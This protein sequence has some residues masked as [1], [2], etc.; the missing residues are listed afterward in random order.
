MHWEDTWPNYPDFQ[1]AVTGLF[2][3]MGLNGVGNRIQSFSSLVLASAVPDNWC[4]KWDLQRREDESKNTT[5]GAAKKPH[6]IVKYRG[7]DIYRGRHRRTKLRQLSGTLK[8][9]A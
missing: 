3:D 2:L 7:G 5:L 4:Q 6:D 1:L 9:I 8:S